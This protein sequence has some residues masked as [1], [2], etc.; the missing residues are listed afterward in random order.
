MAEP[1][2]RRMWPLRL[3][4]G[5]GAHDIVWNSVEVEKVEGDKLGRGAI[6]L[7]FKNVRNDFSWY[8]SGVYGL[9]SREDN[10]LGGIALVSSQLN[11]AVVC[12]AT[13]MQLLHHV[14]GLRTKKFLGI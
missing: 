6:S 4:G 8:F 12:V 11:I 14:K 1:N 10:T 13:L 3:V 2:F 5:L 9:Q 7:H